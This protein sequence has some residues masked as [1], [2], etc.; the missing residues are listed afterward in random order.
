MEL[1]TVERFKSN[2]PARSHL[3]LYVIPDGT[4]PITSVSEDYKNTNATH[5]VS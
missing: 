3:G 4:F 2:I 5:T 1:H